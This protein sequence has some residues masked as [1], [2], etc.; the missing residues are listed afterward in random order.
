MLERRPFLAAMTVQ[1]VWFK[2][3]L[4]AGDHDPLLNAARRGPVLPI[5]IFEPTRW[6][7]DDASA[8]QWA[9]VRA[10]LME[11]RDELAALGQPLIVRVGEVVPVLE[12]LRQTYGS[13]SLWSHQET[14]NGWTYAR[15][16]RVRAWARERAVTWTELPQHGV[17]RGLDTR[18]GWAARWDR[19][20][21]KP[22]SRRPEA[23]QEL[24]WLDPG[25]L[26]TASNL[27][28]G[29]DDCPYLPAGGRAAGLDLL[30]SFLNHRGER[31][32]KEMSS[33]NTAY[34]ACSRLSTH[35]AAGTVSIREAAQACR[36]R[37]AEVRESPPDRRGT[38]LAA[39]RAFEG[40]LHWHCHFIQ[41]L[42]DQPSLEFENQHPAYDGMREDA[43]DRGRFEAWSRGETGFPFVDACMRALH[44]TGWI[45]FRMRA[46]LAAFS[47]YHLW[48]HWREPGLHLAQL[49]VDYEPGIHYP[50]MQMQSGTTGINTPRIYNPVKQSLDQDPDGTFIRRW[51][52][53]LQA[54]TTAH[55]HEPWK[56]SGDAQR[57]A[58]CIIGKNYPAPIVDHMRAAREA[59]NRIWAVRRSDHYRRTADAIQ[60][61]HGSRK[62][63][64][65]PSNPIRTK[66]L[67]RRKQLN[68]EV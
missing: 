57:S 10:S 42:E 38:W 29:P 61:K 13:L 24:G 15:D 17:I 32:H 6:R 43:F 35:F 67:R 68:L 33:P 36:T 54:V 55:I 40:R 12:D 46:M 30:R 22:I 47:A 50:Q 5:Y 66:P 20:M 52:P 1:V 25:L 18:D 34:D 21:E 64:L 3:D 28:L 9:F 59:R 48:L 19:F 4:R 23:L 7:Q 16:R 45:N 60:E 63:G 62:S 31:Y 44:E 51:V 11:L 8:R 49:F 53:E 41:K 27:G 65:P 14:G 58:G 39:L 2:R 56:M 37:I 26:P